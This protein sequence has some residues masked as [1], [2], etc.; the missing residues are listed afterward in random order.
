MAAPES[1]AVLESGG[2]EAV[3]ECPGGVGATHS[4]IDAW[5]QER[6][7]AQAHVDAQRR[8][9]I[10]PSLGELPRLGKESASNPTINKSAAKFPLLQ[11]KMPL[12]RSPD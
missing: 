5:P 8:K 4:P 9:P 6:A 7:Q 11:C 1:P 2:R 10:S 3:R 12:E